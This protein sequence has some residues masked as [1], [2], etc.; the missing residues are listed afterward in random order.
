ME[1]PAAGSPAAGGVVRGGEVSRRR[2]EEAGARALAVA[3]EPVAAD[4]AV[5]EDLLAAQEVSLGDRQRV[6]G[7][8]VA[9]VD[10]REVRRLLELAA[11]RHELRVGQ[12]LDDRLF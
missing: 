11:R 2:R 9:A 6:A 7:E 12:G 8:P 4:A 10:L 3:G 1:P 5:E